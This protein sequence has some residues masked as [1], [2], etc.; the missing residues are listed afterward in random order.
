MD[1]QPG[2]KPG[3]N[4][5]QEVVTTVESDRREVEPTVNNEPVV[6]AEA[7]ALA[8]S[9]DTDKAEPTAIE[10]KPASERLSRRVEEVVNSRNAER[11][12]R[13]R[14]E[15]RANLLQEQ[16]QRIANVP[17]SKVEQP[18]P[19]KT[20]DT[21]LGYPTD[22]REFA[23]WNRQEATKAAIEATQEASRQSKEQA[24][25]AEL[26]KN[27]PDVMSDYRLQGA[28]AAER[29]EAA[30]KGI[31]MTWDE[32]AKTV[33]EAFSSQQKKKAIDDAVS[34]TQSKNEAYVE[35]TKGASSSRSPAPDPKSKMTLSEMEEYLKSQGNWN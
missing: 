13:I 1:I 5:P 28:V 32:A 4:A 18:S 17:S 2:L 12:A 14:A 27:H 10:D 30:R 23:Q 8:N 20:F 26:N 19:F 25:F 7:P 29:S 21:E 3:A 33:K 35:T 9:E 34:D 16:M 15:E 11:E 24:E 31:H 22:P 6:E